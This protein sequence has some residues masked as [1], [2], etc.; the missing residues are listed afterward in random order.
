MCP[1]SSRSSPIKCPQCGSADLTLDQARGILQGP[2]RLKALRRC[3]Q[4]GMLFEPPAGKLL[5]GIVTLFGLAAIALPW[6]DLVKAIIAKD[7]CGVLS[8][9]VFVIVLFPFGVNMASLGFQSL[10]RAIRQPP[11]PKP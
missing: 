1:T 5:S 10:L 3:R 7:L 4:C 6:P 11:P 2:F 9:S 8:K